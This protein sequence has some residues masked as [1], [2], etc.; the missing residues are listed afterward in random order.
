MSMK[1]GPEAAAKDLKSQNSAHE[2]HGA[3][4]HPTKDPTGPRDGG[5]MSYHPSKAAKC[6]DEWDHE[7]PYNGGEGK[8]RHKY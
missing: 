4:T 1:Y 8:G 5:G 3:G 2:P 6:L 7:A